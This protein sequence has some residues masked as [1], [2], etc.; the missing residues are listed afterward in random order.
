VDL[1]ADRLG[2]GAGHRQRTDGLFGCS[3]SSTTRP[4]P[5]VVL[6][7]LVGF[8]W[9]GSVQELIDGHAACRTWW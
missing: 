3:N 2:G 6:G 4:T 8:S 1:W 5:A 7:G 9:V